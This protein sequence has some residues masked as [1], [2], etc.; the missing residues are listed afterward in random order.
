MTPPAHHEA[1]ETTLVVPATGAGCRLDDFLADALAIGR[2]AAVRLAARSRVNGRHARKGD[3][4]REGDVLLVPA[5]DL[6]ADAPPGSAL[7][8][9]RETTDVVVLDKP[10]GLPTVALRG[11]GGDSLAARIAARFPECSAVG[12][13]GESG[14]VHRLDTGTSGL[15]LAA[16]TPAAYAA[17]RAQFRDHA[18]SKEYL[19]L[20]AGRLEHA[21]RIDAPIGQHRASLRRV[22]AI[23]TPEA[24]RRYAARDACTEVVPERV[25]RDATVVRAR[26]STGARHQIRVHLASVGHPLLGDPLYG[27]GQRGRGGDDGFLLHASRIE[28]TDPATGLRT[29]DETSPPPA[30]QD[31]LARLS[32]DGLAAERAR[33]DAC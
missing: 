20:V 22:R 26:T 13:P 10:A 4:L 30:W 29:L 17:L 33:P 16:R 11:A 5:T 15:L 2:R 1:R 19:A 8:V 21:V 18:V 25:L 12:G 31:R 14:L 23:A 24:A 3:R 9:V 28:W 6:A 27:D 7:T 32:G